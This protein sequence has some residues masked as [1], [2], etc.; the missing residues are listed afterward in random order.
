MEALERLLRGAHDLGAPAAAFYAAR[1]RRLWKGPTKALTPDGVVRTPE[2]DDR[3]HVL[4]VSAPLDPY[5][6][7]TCDWR[8]GELW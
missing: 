4:R 3:V 1:G 8:D 7:L 2:D 6:A 5:G